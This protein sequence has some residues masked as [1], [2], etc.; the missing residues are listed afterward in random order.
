MTA[1]STAAKAAARAMAE[2][3]KAIDQAKL[4]Y[5]FSPGSYTHGV[6]SACLAAEQ[7]LAVLRASLEG[8]E[9]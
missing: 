6:L 9:Q 5:E 3:R 4:A 8:M 2:N 1:G 7:A